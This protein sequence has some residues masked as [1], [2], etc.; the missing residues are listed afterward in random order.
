MTAVR[1]ETLQNIG[2]RTRQRKES[3]ALRH[4]VQ[5]GSHVFPIHQMEAKIS[6]KAFLNL[7]GAIEGKEK[8]EES[9]ADAV[10]EELKNWAIHHG[11]TH[12]THWFQPLTHS[13]G[14]KHDSFLSWSEKGKVIE[15]FRGKELLRG[16]P[17]ASS[18][19]SGG[20]R[21]THQARGYTTWDLSSPPFLWE[22][23]DGMTLCIP[24]V[25]FSWKG[26]ALDHKLPLLRS[27]EK[28]NKTVL[29]LLELCGIP[30]GR[31]FSTLGAEQ[32]YFAIDRSFYLLRPDLLLAGRT[33]YGA[34]PAKGQELEDHY[35]GSVKDRIMAYMRE[36]EDLAI[37]LGIPLKTRHNEVAPAQHEAAPLFEKASIA[38]DHNLLLM[39]IMRQVAIK[40]DL[41]CLFHEKPFAHIN[42]SGKHNNWSLGTD[43]GLNLLDP[44]EN[45]L[46]FITLLTAILRAVHEHAGLLRASI[47]S[48]GNDHRLGGN[49]APPTILSVYLGDALE[50]IVDQ[51]VHGREEKP[52][53]LR[54]IDLGLSGLPHQEADLSDRN[55]TSFFAFTGNKFEFRAVGA[56]AHSA[57]PISVINAIVSDSLQLLLDEISDQVKDKKLSQEE[58]FKAALPVLQKHLKIAKPVIFSG[59]GYSE[60]WVQEAEARGLPNIRKSFHAF[61]QFLNKKTETVFEGILSEEEL[62]SRFEIFVEQYAKT[63]NIETNLMIELFRTQILPAALQDQKNRAKSLAALDKLAESSPIQLQSLKNLKAAID[64]AISH[65]DDLEKIQ[66][67]TQDLGWEAKGKVFCELAAPRM[68]M[69]RKS[70][71]TLETLVDNA[72]WPLPKYRE[73]LYVV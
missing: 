38:V 41:A 20:L 33:V 8:L 14:E 71:D 18:F 64:E 49:E 15:K 25:F 58:L 10:A 12:F 34:K 61:P 39:E 30:A 26:D 46:A 28:L 1:V 65:I 36:F 11:S 55:R 5:F 57:L 2:K 22:G 69:A 51:I 52:I 42:G 19:P 56:S 40:H 37:R 3:E 72:L 7:Q 13:T 9:T 23:G 70:V 62:H 27:D 4:S 16:E 48:A 73:M 68:E 17:D 63:M 44:K 6:K 24:S 60:E 32:E 43:T 66:S 45:S 67:Q 35:F 50:R 31:V 53:P 29:K 47:G 54:M 59:N 21:S